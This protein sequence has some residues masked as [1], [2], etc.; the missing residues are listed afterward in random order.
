MAHFWTPFLGV[1]AGPGP[2]AHFGPVGPKIPTYGNLNWELLARRA[3]R[4]PGRPGPQKRGQKRGPK[5]PKKGQKWVKKWGPLLR[6]FF[7]TWPGP[8][9]K[10]CLYSYEESS[11]DPE[12][13]GQE[14]GL[15]KWVQKWPKNRKNGHFLGRKMGHFLGSKIGHFYQFRRSN[16]DPGRSIFGPKKVPKPVRF[17]TGPGPLKTGF[18]HH[19]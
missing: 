15:K 11:G 16:P 17:L 5:P 6:P 4:V 10:G 9:K 19:L 12:L 2:G 13:A 3:R 18:S 8:T 7:Q 1:W 14:K